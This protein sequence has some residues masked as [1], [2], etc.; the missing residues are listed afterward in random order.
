MSPFYLKYF[1]LF[2]PINTPI[3]TSGPACFSDPILGHFPTLFVIQAH[4]QAFSFFFQLLNT[5]YYRALEYASLASW[6]APPI[7]FMV[8]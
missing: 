4:R 2:L 1:A 3:L 7:R 5:S 6:T 8:I